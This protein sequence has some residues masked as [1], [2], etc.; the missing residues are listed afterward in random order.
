MAIDHPHDALPPGY[1]LGSYEILRVLGRGGFGLT[2]QARRSGVAGDM[3]AIKELYPPALARRASNM[4]IVALQGT[5][6]AHITDAIDMFLREA[7]LI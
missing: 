7:Q 4:A 2:Y 1:C 6:E 3:V 5:H